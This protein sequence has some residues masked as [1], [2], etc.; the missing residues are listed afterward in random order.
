[1]SYAQVPDEVLDSAV[2]DRAVRLFA[3]LAKYAGLPDGA[4]PSR[5]KLAE[6]L[7]CSKW[8]VDRALAEL[9]EAKFVQRTRRWD[10]DGEVHEG[11]TRPP[12]ALRLPSRYVVAGVHLG[13]SN[14]APTVV[15]GVH[16]SGCTHLSGKRHTKET[17]QT[18]MGVVG[19]S[20]SSRKGRGGH[21]GGSNNRY[22][23]LDRG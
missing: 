4:R 9:I 6:R 3:L 18:P 10:L 7:R 12:G 11:G 8:S 14:G 22:A 16:L 13:G 23:Y 21:G 17:E 19:S 1:V 15:A 5:A 20:G 2:S